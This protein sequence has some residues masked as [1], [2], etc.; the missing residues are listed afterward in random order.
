MSKSETETEQAAAS[1][2]GGGGEK[3]ATGCLVPDAQAPRDADLAVLRD[4]YPLP[5]G[6]PDESVNR[7]QLARG[8]DVSENTITKWIGQGMPVLQ[9]GGNGR[10]Y[11]FQLGDCFA[12]RMAGEAARDQARQAGDAA[13]SQLAMTFVGAEEDDEDM[14]LTAKQIGDLAEARYKRNKAAEQQRELVR[15][16]RVQVLF[17]AMLTTFVATVESLADFAELEFG[18]DADQIERL[19]RR[20]A[21]ALDI[22]RSELAQLVEGG[23]GETL[24]L[25]RQEALPL[26]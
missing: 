6:V 13:A 7:M 10:E 15:V 24:A 4:R 11:V 14:G 23:A 3:E 2:Q 17:E 19:E 8:M 25:R 16:A 26:E 9:H 12:W 22:C 5:R 21:G 20:C 1:G 18:L